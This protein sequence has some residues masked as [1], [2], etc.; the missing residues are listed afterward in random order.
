[1]RKFLKCENGFIAREHWEPHCWVNIEKPDQKDYAMLSEDFHVPIDY[2]E[3]VTDPEENPR[4]ERDGDWMLTILRLPTHSSGGSEPYTTVPLGII[5][6][7]EICITVCQHKTE[8]ISDF[9]DHTRARGIRIEDTANF[10]LRLIFSSAVWYL[11][12]L[13]KISATVNGAEKEMGSSVQNDQILLLLQL[14]KSLTIFNTSLR[15]NSAIITRLKSIYGDTID[16]DLLED[17]EIELDQARNT[18]DVYSSILNGTMDAFG[19]VISN[20]VNAVMK[21]MTA[22]SIVL[23]VPTLIASFYGMNVLLPLT[24]DSWAFWAI[25][26]GSIVLT[27]LCYMLFRKIKWV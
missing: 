16:E 15:G 11:K 25:L 26:G 3:Y 10:I 7:G 17:I 21:R 5:T 18:V 24:S 20:N 9:I 14:Q 2:I 8:M 23:M 1:M 12:Y 19:S 27:A 22:V 4:V 6:N 13:T